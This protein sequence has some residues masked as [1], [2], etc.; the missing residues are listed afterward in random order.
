MKQ[1][2]YQSLY[3]TGSIFETNLLNF[4]FKLSKVACSIASWLVVSHDKSCQHW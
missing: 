3:P 2:R 4:G 1:L